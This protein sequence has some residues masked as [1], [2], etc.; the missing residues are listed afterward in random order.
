MTDNESSFIHWSIYSILSWA[1]KVASKKTPFDTFVSFHSAKFIEWNLLYTNQVHTQV[2]TQYTEGRYRLSYDR[3][4]GRK[5]LAPP[6]RSLSTGGA[7]S[8]AS[9]PNHWLR[10][11]ECPSLR[12]SEH[13]SAMLWSQAWAS[14]VSGVQLLCSLQGGM[15]MFIWPCSCGLL[16]NNP[17]WSFCD[18]GHSG[19]T[20]RA[21]PLCT[22]WHYCHG[23]HGIYF[24][25]STKSLVLYA[26]YT[27][28]G[29]S[30]K[31]CL[32]TKS[33]NTVRFSN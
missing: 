33:L 22:S 11:A 14:S 23:S 27:S 1:G 13:L 4:K 3:A 19:H 15:L 26:L 28:G 6:K 2:N 7:K 17:G 16:Q 31:D 5:Y 18:L 30:H 21:S 20:L 24:V 12:L 9:I 25:K 32:E 29:Y 8:W 10:W